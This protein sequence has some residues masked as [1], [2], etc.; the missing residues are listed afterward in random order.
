VP[1]C[2]DIG[3]WSDKNGES[4]QDLI[5]SSTENQTFCNNEMVKSLGDVRRAISAITPGRSQ[6]FRV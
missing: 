1:N 3:A 5:L 4:T 2:R 6:D